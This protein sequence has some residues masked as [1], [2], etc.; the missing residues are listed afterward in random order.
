[1]ILIL[2]HY[3]TQLQS[4]NQVMSKH[5]NIRYT[6]WHGTNIVIQMLDFIQLLLIVGGSSR[7]QY[8]THTDNATLEPQVSISH[9]RY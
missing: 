6:E 4:D 7:H 1:M 2:S 8:N 9:P 5:L 3:T